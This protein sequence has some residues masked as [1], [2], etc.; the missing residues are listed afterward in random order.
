[1]KRIFIIL[2]LL[3]LVATVKADS[4]E[5][6]ED[7]DI[8]RATKLTPEGHFILS[9]WGYDKSCISKLEVMNIIDLGMDFNN[10]NYIEQHEYIQKS[11]CI[12]EVND[13]GERQ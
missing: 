4:V 10:L 5:W 7:R 8:Y 13:K 11:K 1:M 12:F 6:I 9:F 3:F 2:F